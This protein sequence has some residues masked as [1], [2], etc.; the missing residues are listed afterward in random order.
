VPSGASRD[1]HRRSRQGVTD[2]ETTGR[3]HSFN[4]RKILAGCQ[5]CIAKRPIISYF[6]Q[7]SIFSPSQTAWHRTSRA[8]L[9]PVT[10]FPM[11]PSYS[12]SRSPHPPPGGDSTSTVGSG[13]GGSMASQTSGPRSSSGSTRSQPSRGGVVSSTLV[14]FREPAKPVVSPTNNCRRSRKALPTF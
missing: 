5:R 9:R 8:C 3:V 10:D 6:T 1:P 13:I 4:T 12:H 2:A 11:Q 14:F 7:P